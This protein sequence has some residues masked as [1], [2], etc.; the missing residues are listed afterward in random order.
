MNEVALNVRATRATDKLMG[1]ETFSLIE[2]LSLK[3][4]KLRKKLGLTKLLVHTMT[5][6]SDI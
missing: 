4:H 3:C 2:M 1:T 5:L 6:S